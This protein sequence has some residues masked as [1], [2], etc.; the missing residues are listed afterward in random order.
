MMIMTLNYQIETTDDFLIIEVANKIV[1]GTIAYSLFVADESSLKLGRLT[2][3]LFTLLDSTS[4]SYSL[5]LSTKAVKLFFFI[6][7]KNVEEV[8]KTIS[9]VSRR[10]DKTIKEGS[11]LLFSP[12]NPK[13]YQKRLK[14]V[15]DASFKAKNKP[16]ILNSTNNGLQIFFTIKPKSE[17]KKIQDHSTISRGLWSFIIELLKAAK[18]EIFLSK[19]INHKKEDKIKFGILVSRKVDSTTEAEAFINY[20]FK[21]SQNYSGRLSSRIK[22]LT[23]NDL[24]NSRISIGFGLSPDLFEEELFTHFDMANIIGNVNLKDDIYKSE[25]TIQQLKRPNRISSENT[26]GLM[27]SSSLDEDQNNIDYSTNSII[28]ISKKEDKNKIGKKPPQHEK[29]IVL[30]GFMSAFDYLKINN[31]GVKSNESTIKKKKPPVFEYGKAVTDKEIKRMI[32]N[33][34]LPPQ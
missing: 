10:I 15:L 7:K 6:K 29:D 13:F 27:Q 30:N 24:N 23:Q 2:D 16:Y 1:I 11:L 28:T 32:E 9:V 18:C 17:T 25:K 14:N 20:L 12:I 22:F 8:I 31:K 34:P 5:H 26:V 19:Q 33:I 4:L 21:T 3:T